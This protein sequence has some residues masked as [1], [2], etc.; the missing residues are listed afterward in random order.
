ME[1]QTTSVFSRSWRI[2]F[3]LQPESL[4]HVSDCFEW[5]R[6]YCQMAFPLSLET[7]S[8]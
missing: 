2:G 1:I 6:E 3:V 4:N 8:S 5:M 7:H